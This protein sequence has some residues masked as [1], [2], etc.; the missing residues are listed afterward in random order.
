[1]PDIYAADLS[2]HYSTRS[3]LADASLTIRTGE[4]VG[5]VGPDASGKTTLGRIL[6]GVETAGSGPGATG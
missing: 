1:M 5:L 4:R 3:I 6:A 2:R